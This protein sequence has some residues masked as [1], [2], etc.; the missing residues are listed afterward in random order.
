[1][2]EKYIF[3]FIIFQSFALVSRCSVSNLFRCIMY[4]AERC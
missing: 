1:M 2:Y 3:D 4:I